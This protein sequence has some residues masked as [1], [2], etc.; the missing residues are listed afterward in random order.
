MAGLPTASR[1]AWR[2]YVRAEATGQSR[3]IE[4]KMRYE[5]GFC[6]IGN[7]GKL[8]AL[9]TDLK[10]RLGLF[11]IDSQTGESEMLETAGETPRNFRDAPGFQPGCSVDGKRTLFARLHIGSP[12]EPYSVKLIWREEGGP[13]K[14]VLRV[15]PPPTGSHCNCRLTAAGSPTPPDRNCTCRM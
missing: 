15:S 7:T 2:I 5:N 12:G 11:R 9:G 6:W 14:E 8:L 3:Q 10:G 1:Q 13:E 4:P